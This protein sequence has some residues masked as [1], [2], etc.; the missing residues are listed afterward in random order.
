MLIRLLVNFLFLRSSIDCISPSLSLSVLPRM[1]SV[2]HGNCL[3]V[4]LPAHGHSHGHGHSHNHSHNKSC[5]SA[6]L[7]TSPLSLPKKDDALLTHGVIN[8]HSTSIY[9]TH[10]RHN[11]F[12]KT[13]PNGGNLLLDTSE[14]I[15]NGSS[16]GGAST[17]A[18]NS[19]A[20]VTGDKAFTR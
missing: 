12:S 14:I 6:Q 5:K 19:V 4:P 13:L 11:S 20:T 15:I 3:S 7:S 10:S 18:P 1:A 17:I 16:G 2:L 9:T 8:M